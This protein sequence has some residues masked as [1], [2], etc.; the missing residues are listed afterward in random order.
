MKRKDGINEI[1][2][3]KDIPYISVE[4]KELVNGSVVK[5]KSIFIKGHSLKECKIIYDRIKKEGY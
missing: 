4:N 2:F 5:Q 3:E 1:V